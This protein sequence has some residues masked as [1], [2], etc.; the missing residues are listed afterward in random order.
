MHNVVSAWRL[1][2]LAPSRKRLWV[3]ALATPA[4]LAPAW[5]RY[6]G[7]LP[8][9]LGTVSGLVLLLLLA[10]CSVTDVSC[11]K[12]CNWATYSAAAWALAIN[13][14]APFVAGSMSGLGAIGPERSLIGLAGCF[15][16][17]LLVYQLAGGG[18]GD[19]KLAAAIGALIGFELGLLAI[20]ATYIVAGATL[21]AWTTWTRGPWALLRAMARLIGSMLLP[22]WVERPTSAA[23]AL[24][25][26][27]VPL[28]G[29]FAIGTLAV[30]LEIV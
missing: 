18:A 17:M 7:G 8:E 16:V 26:Q 30:V 20:A 15:G 22:L 13:C 10:S 28:A 12:I 2:V 21:L 3:I 14:A 27:P 11:R 29:F 24:L 25:R 6:A 5:S 19:V 1:P 9:P 23:R 4:V